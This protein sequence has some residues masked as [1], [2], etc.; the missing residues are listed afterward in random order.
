MSHIRYGI[1]VWHHSHIAI[2]KK[3]QACANKFLRVIFFLKPRES[4]RP[5]MKEHNILSVNQIYQVEVSKL[6]QKYVLKSIPS[7]FVKMFQTQ[8]RT[9]TTSTRSGTSI[10]QAPFSTL[11]CTQSIRCSGPKIWNSVPKEIRYM[12]TNSLDF[13][14]LNPNP[15]KLFVSKMKEYAIQNIDFI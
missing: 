7:P 5:I 15:L 10:I 12:P 9:T 6:M 11:K 1:V 13:S 14:N 3:I 8:T 4:V 2:R